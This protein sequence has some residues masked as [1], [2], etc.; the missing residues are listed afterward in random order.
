VDGLT[1]AATQVP[2]SGGDDPD[3][4]A[5]GDA[6]ADGDGVPV[7]LPVHTVPLN[8]SCA[9]APLLPLNDALKPM[10][11]VPFVATGPLYEAL[12]TVTLS[13]VCVT[14]PFQSC[15][16]CWLPGNVQPTVHEATGLPR[17]VTETLPVNPPGHW[18]PI[19]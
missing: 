3:G 8:V 11:S 4:D 12:V 13:P 19:E 17:F 9:G 6:D 2:A 5:D 7:T 1:G 15:V 18:L 10:L 16:I 14:T